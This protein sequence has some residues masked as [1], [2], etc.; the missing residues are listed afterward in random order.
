MN[1][2]IN[3][4]LVRFHK[5]VLELIHYFDDKYENDTDQCVDIINNYNYK[6]H[7]KS[8]QINDQEKRHNAD[9]FRDEK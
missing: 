8:E 7:L 1:R 3:W 9:V 5:I 6:M 2:F 4:F